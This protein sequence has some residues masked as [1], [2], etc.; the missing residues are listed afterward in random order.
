MNLPKKVILVRH[1]MR[2]P[3]MDEL[4][5]FGREQ[6]RHVAE[7]IKPHCPTEGTLLLTST[8][9][10]GRQSAEIIAIALG[11]HAEERDCLWTESRRPFKMDDLLACVDVGNQAKVVILVTHLEVLDWLPEELM[12]WCLDVRSFKPRRNLDQGS[13]VI[14]DC[15]QKTIAYVEALE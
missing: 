11:L 4:L 6:M 7:Q 13:A 12:R 8:S 3:P 10:R 9:N 2:M 1:G 5:P 15:E 14:I